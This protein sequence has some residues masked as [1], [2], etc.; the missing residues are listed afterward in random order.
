MILLRM[1]SNI[2]NDELNEKPP[3]A[4]QPASECSLLPC[5]E[6]VGCV[7]SAI[8]GGAAVCHNFCLHNYILRYMIIS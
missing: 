2:V 7:Q 1:S 8:I 4:S 5:L 6:L 3:P